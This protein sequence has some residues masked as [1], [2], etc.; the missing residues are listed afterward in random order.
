MPAKQEVI[1]KFNLITGE[2]TYAGQASQDPATARRLQSLIPSLKGEL[3]REAGE[4]KYLP[5]LIG[6]G[7]KV[8]ELFQYDYNDTSGN[9]QTKRFAATATQ[10]Y[11]EVGGAW[12]AQ[13]IINPATGVNTSTPFAGYPTFKI[14]NNL[15][16]FSDGVNNWIYDGP[17]AAFVQDGLP[18]PT[19]TIG[20]VG[21][22][23]GAIT[24]LIGRYYWFT[25]ADETVG[26]VHESSSSPIS[27]STGPLTAKSV[28]LS[29]SPDTINTT[30]GSATVTSVGAAFTPAMVGLALHLGGAF[31]G[32]YGTIIAFI[33]PTTMTL[34]VPAFASNGA[35]SY[36]LAPVRA[37]AVHV[38]ASES[39]GSRLGKFLFSVNLNVFTINDNSPFL[40]QPGSTI[41]SIDRPIRNDPPPPSSVIEPHKYR[42]FRRRET[43]P[44][45][46]TY[47]ANEEVLAGTNGSPQESVPGTAS[48]TLSDII[49]ETAYPKPALA[50]RALKSHMDALYI[51]TE[52]E[53]IP[54]WGD[55]IDSFALSQVTAI[56]GGVIS[57]WGMESTSHGLVIFSYDRKLYLYPPISPIYALTP[58]DINVTDQLTELG[59]AMRTKFLTIKA[60]DI[61][62]VRILKYKYNLRDWLVV[63]YQDTNSV[64][65]TYIYDF[66]TK[67]WTE[68]QRGFVSVGVFETSPGVKILVGGG[69]DGFVYVA[70]DPTGAIT[71]NPTL[72][73][74]V[75][76]TSLIDFGH[77]DILHL[78]KYLEIEVSNPAIM[79]LSTTVNFYLDPT[80][81]DNLPDPIALTMFPVPGEPTRYR[82]WFAASEGGQ[83]VICRRL[84]VEFNLATDVN[85][86]SF[87]G[88]VLKADPVSGMMR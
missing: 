88:I 77:P 36:I 27:A 72:P 26:R 43:I 37:T 64:Y 49:D 23:A 83:G 3:I 11:M 53:V 66:E 13:S 75:F 84:M 85:A 24:A 80:D 9:Q 5:T 70:D 7:A 58:E 71:A 76:R 15:L 60:T 10:L 18:I 46:F 20:I 61:Q 55:S 44:N 22:S 52:K 32:L 74:A 57:R 39:D 48:N 33:S 14:I 62:N 38:Y 21:T 16:H 50:I 79:D 40:N 29:L 12:A 78:P 6:S 45:R 59:I 87:R 1:T 4:A 30:S 63:C 34:S 56:D 86:G 65:H 19:T 51:G 42:L 31:S 25:F 17:N 35:A 47:T 28:N 67:G 73:V 41:M 2:S 81:A 68:L 82:G 69:A 54:L 8:G